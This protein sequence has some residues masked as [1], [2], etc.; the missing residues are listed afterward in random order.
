MGNNVTQTK[1]L[2]ISFIV[3]SIFSIP[4]AIALDRGAVSAVLSIIVPLSLVSYL[5]IVRLNEA[6]KADLHGIIAFSKWFYIGTFIATILLMI[7][8]GAVFSG[9]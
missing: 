5:L 9:G 3:I 2:L 1:R 8:L 4:A 6:A 7:A